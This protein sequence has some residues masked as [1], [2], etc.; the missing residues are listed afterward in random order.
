[1]SSIGNAKMK[2]HAED[3]RAKSIAILS[4]PKEW[5]E[6][7]VNDSPRETREQ[8]SNEYKELA[9]YFYKLGKIADKEIEGLLSE[10]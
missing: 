8:R 10:A 3:Y 7:D 1:M 9:R 6:F 2:S 5:I 4:A